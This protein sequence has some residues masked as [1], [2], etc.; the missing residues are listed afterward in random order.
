MYKFG[1]A[2]AGI[3]SVGDASSGVAP[4]VDGLAQGHVHDPPGGA[5]LLL[6]DP[7]VI[8]MVIGGI[9][10]RGKPRYYYAAEET[11]EASK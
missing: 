1:V 6:A 8:A 3:V 4:N 5:G 7:T 11:A 10:Y 9:V 2:A